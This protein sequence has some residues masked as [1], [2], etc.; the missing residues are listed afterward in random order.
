MSNTRNHSIGLKVKEKQESNPGRPS[1]DRM[2]DNS[3]GK[4][5]LRRWVLSFERNVETNNELRVSGGRESWSNDRK[6]PFTQRCSDIW[7]GQNR[8]VNCIYFRLVNNCI[9]TLIFKSVFVSNFL[10]F[11]CIIVYFLY[12]SS[13]MIIL[14]V[15]GTHVLLMTK[16]VKTVSN[17]FVNVW[18]T[19]KQE[20]QLDN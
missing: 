8:D 13:S 5:N 11:S 3:R 4:A 7:D 15:C 9:S 16:Q 14:L 20:N 12:D 2:G 17:M 10:R 19:L 1:D 18:H 6:G